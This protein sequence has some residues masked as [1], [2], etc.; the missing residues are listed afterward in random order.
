MAAWSKFDQVLSRLGA[1]DIVT[2]LWDVV[3][4]S[5]VVDWFTHI[6]RDLG[7]HSIDWN[8][9]DIRRMGFSRKTEW[10]GRVKVDSSYTGY[11]ETITLPTYYEGPQC[12]QKTYTRTQGFPPGTQSV[13]LFGNLNKTQIAEGLAL[14]VQRI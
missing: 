2:A 4:Y 10:Y 7:A 13:G 3:P 1:R 9:Y 6:N 5:F 8:S 12:V 11:G 14:I